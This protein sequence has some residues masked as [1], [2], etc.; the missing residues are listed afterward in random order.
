MNSDVSEERSG[1]NNL[2]FEMSAE[3]ESD[4]HGRLGHAYVEH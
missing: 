3:Y 4:S 2:F 1:I